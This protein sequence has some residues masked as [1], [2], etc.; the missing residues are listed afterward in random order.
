MDLSWDIVDNNAV[1]SMRDSMMGLCS[2][3]S[4]LQDV[5]FR[6]CGFLGGACNSIFSVEVPALAGS[7]T[8]VSHRDLDVFLWLPMCPH[9]LDHFT[10]LS[11][12]YRITIERVPRGS[13]D[14]MLYTFVHF[15]QAA[16]Q[17][18]SS[19]LNSLVASILLGVCS[20]S[21][22]REWYGEILIV[23]SLADSTVVNMTS[24]DFLL[25]PGMLKEVVGLRDDHDL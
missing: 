8:I 23:K 22:W 11:D 3:R 5:E 6:S 18:I 25:V 1:Y 21:P 9:L 17:R 20:S 12:D 4:C 16:I 10:D 19:S 7:P 2:M 24:A 13:D 14:R 15:N